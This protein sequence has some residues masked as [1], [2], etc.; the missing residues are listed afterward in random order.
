MSNDIAGK[1]LY[2]RLADPSGKKKDIINHHRVWSVERFIA[3]Q[4]D[5]HTGPTVQHGDKRIV[6]LATKE[7]YL[8]GGA[9]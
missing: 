1:D 7:D 2:V 9:V 3:A 5:Q 8:Q 4:Q 6:S